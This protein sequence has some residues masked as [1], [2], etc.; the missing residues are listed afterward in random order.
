M[1]SDE[2]STKGMYCWGVGVGRWSEYSEALLSLV[3]FH[4]TRR[5]RGKERHIR[6]LTLPKHEP[7]MP[8]P[9]SSIERSTQGTARMRHPTQTTHV[10]S[11]NDNGMR[12]SMS[13]VD[14][15]RRR[16]SPRNTIIPPGPSRR[17]G[18][19]TSC[20]V[21]GGGRRGTRGGRT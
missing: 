13:I 11:R 6:T 1:S 4:E 8:S 7:P 3:S 9:A 15:K 16:R 14:T 12:P 2:E 18:P 19:R 5:E 21:C 10:T 20:P 17:R